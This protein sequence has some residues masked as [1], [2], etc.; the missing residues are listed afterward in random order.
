[1]KI[2]RLLKILIY[3]TEPKQKHTL[4][5]KICTYQIWYV[6]NILKDRAGERNTR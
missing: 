5:G 1:M 2:D 3:Q 4:Q 6:A